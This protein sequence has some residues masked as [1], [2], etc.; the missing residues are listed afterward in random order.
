MIGRLRRTAMYDAAATISAISKN[1][2]TPTP[3]QRSA[4]AALIE[5]PPLRLKRK[6]M[7][8]RGAG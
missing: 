4:G 8:S 6:L 2:P 7:S 5:P 3:I 1:A